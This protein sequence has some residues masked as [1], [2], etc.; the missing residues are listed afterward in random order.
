METST[1]AAFEEQ[2]SLQRSTM[3]RVYNYYRILISFL[4]MFLFIDKNFGEFVGAVNPA[5]FQQTIVIYLIANIIIGFSPLVISKAFIAR[6]SVSF[7]VLTL[8]IIGLSLLM[9]ASGGVAS[10]LGNFL[11]FTV[12]FA[13]GLIHGK[14]S[15][16]LPAIAF[17]LTLYIEFYLFFLDQNEM[18][19]FFQAGILGIVYFV[20]NIFFQSLSRQLHRRESEVFTLEQI[21]QI[22][23][24]QMRSGVAVVNKDGELKLINAS[25]KQMIYPQDP[26]AEMNA[27]P[28]DLMAKVDSTVT[29]NLK[30][31]FTYSTVQDAPA[32]LVTLSKIRT[33]GAQQDSLL[34][35]EDSTEIQRKAQQLKLAAL[36][37][38]SASIAHEIRN[39]L[40]AISHAAQLLSESQD[41]DSGDKRLS[42]IIQNHCVRMNS[43]IE[44]V[45][46][47]SRRKTAEPKKIDLNDFLK[48]FVEEFSVGYSEHC[49]IDVTNYPGTINVDFDP[50]H[51]SQVLGNLCQNGLRYSAKKTGSHKVSIVV[52]IEELSGVAYLT[53]IDFGAGVPNDLIGNLFEPFYTTETSGTGLGLYLSKELCEANNAKLSYSNSD[54]RGSCF[55]IT[56]F[57]SS[58]Y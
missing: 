42:D 51:L 33:S 25:G 16:V 38:L 18:Q 20:S 50:I 55:H 30:Q 3:L 48:D 58:R 5:L 43:V 34:F 52:G 31:T 47:M 8:D 40:G 36:G 23:V 32:L 39:P 17:I 45:L 1:E 14:I 19:R 53:V 9:A 49:Q 27:L 10:G 4:F 24:D 22:V 56:F 37:R 35:F 57:P 54:V 46:Q 15:T 28:E 11:I 7:V 2:H 6:P 41:L 26:K 21:N 44:N 13:G 12:A 29:G